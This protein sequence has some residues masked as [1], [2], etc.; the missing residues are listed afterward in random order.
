[1]FNS[2]TWLLMCNNVQAYNI[3]SLRVT[4]TSFV[5]PEGSTIAEL[6]NFLINFLPRKVD[7]QTTSHWMQCLLKSNRT[8]KP[9]KVSG[10]CPMAPLISVFNLQVWWLDPIMHLN[11]GFYDPLGPTV[12]SLSLNVYQMWVFKGSQDLGPCLLIRLSTTAL[13]GAKGSS[14]PS[15]YAFLVLHCP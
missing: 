11:N 14:L 5:N 3:Q 2:N 7:T 8:G 15:A 6:F 4:R 10:F 13:I 12:L 9:C 1:M